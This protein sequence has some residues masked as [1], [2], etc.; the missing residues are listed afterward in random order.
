[1]RKIDDRID[2]LDNGGADVD[3][4]DGGKEN[5]EQVDESMVERE[6]EKS[7]ENKGQETEV[8]GDRDGDVEMASIRVER[9]TD[10]GKQREEVNEEVNSPP[11]SLFPLFYLYFY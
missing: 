4:E 7:S 5:E 2:V 1:L 9:P 8:V 11:V 6:V 3:G 10:K